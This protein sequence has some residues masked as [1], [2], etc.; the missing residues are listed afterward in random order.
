MPSAL[1]EL[2]AE[3]E[4]KEAEL[5][6]A[7]RQIMRMKNEIAGY[8]RAMLDITTDHWTS[9]KLV[10]ERDRL[11]TDTSGSSS[12]MGRYLAIIDAIA[13]MDEPASKE[14][15]DCPECGGF[16]VLDAGLTTRQYCHCAT[17]RSHLAQAHDIHARHEVEKGGGA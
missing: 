17:G 3:V 7:K 9:T 8:D 16:G 15:G 13:A 12:L 1:A 11:G 2:E 14:A 6:D 4:A 10:I 5:T